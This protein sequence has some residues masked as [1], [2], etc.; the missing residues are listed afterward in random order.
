MCCIEVLKY[1]LFQHQGYRYIHARNPCLVA[2]IREPLWADAPAPSR[3]GYPGPCLTSC[4]SCQN[5][6]PNALKRTRDKDQLLPTSHCHLGP[7][8]TTICR[9]HQ[10]ILAAS[11]TP[12][13]LDHAACILA[14]LRRRSEHSHLWHDLTHLSMLKLRS[15]RLIK[16]TNASILTRKPTLASPKASKPL[17]STSPDTGRSHISESRVETVSMDQM[18][19][20]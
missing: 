14:S 12:S 5:C 1:F 8:T 13:T 11:T 6:R 20:S 7:T 16:A 2:E 18:S 15:T 4:Q 10:L 9:L 19:V 17:Y 3:P